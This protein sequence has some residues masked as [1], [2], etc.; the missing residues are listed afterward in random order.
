M[1]IQ[2]QI[3][4]VRMC[5][6]GIFLQYA[7]WKVEYARIGWS[8]YVFHG[9]HGAAESA[10][11]AHKSNNLRIVEKIII[12]LN[13]TWITVSCWRHN[14]SYLYGSYIRT[15]VSLFANTK[16]IIFY[17]NVFLTITTNIAFT[18]QLYDDMVK[19][20]CRRL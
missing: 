1:R 16:L 14:I 12:T 9:G 13:G 19:W 18:K 4:W 17:F 7:N 2:T 8:T 10:E 15:H 11:S 3:L 5:I 20:I 6:D